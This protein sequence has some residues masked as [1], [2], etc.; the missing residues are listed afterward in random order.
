[1]ANGPVIE[2]AA[3]QKQNVRLF[4]ILVFSPILLYIG[5]TGNMNNTIR[6]ILVLM[7]LGTL[8]YN[9]YYYFKYKQ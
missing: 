2:N 1:M 5:L 8:L 4:D 3:V 7:G 6:T 9:G